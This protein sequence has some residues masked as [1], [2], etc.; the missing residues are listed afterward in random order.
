MRHRTR[1]A[2][3]TR[4]TTWDGLARLLSSARS[5]S[6]RA[7][8]RPFTLVHDPGQLGQMRRAGEHAEV[9]EALAGHQDSM[10]GRVSFVSSMCGRSVTRVPSA[11]LG[12]VRIGGIK[13]FHGALFASR[14]L[15]RGRPP[16]DSPGDLDETPA[17]QRVESCA[18][19]LGLDVP[20][21]KGMQLC[22]IELLTSTRATSTVSASGSMMLPK[23]T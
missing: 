1:Q 9:E 14:T 6:P 23:I 4:E 21:R 11:P 13:V 19:L 3:R 8:W 17:A 20:S 2:G 15:R 22:S 10:Q 5:G 7:G 18:E 12:E 16:L